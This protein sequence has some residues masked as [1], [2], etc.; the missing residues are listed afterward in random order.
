MI[1][2]VIKARELID[3]NRDVTNS[4]EVLPGGGGGVPCYLSEF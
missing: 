2:T 1:V 4:N 3:C